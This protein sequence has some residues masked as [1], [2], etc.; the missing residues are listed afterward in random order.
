MREIISIIATIAAGY[1]G[2]HYA[3]SAGYVL[4]APPKPPAVTGR[5]LPSRRASAEV[6]KIGDTVE[7][8]VAYARQAK[9]PSGSVTLTAAII[10]VESAANPLAHN[11]DGEDSRGLMQVQLSTARGLH[12]N[13]AIPQ[14]DR[15][16]LGTLLFDPV[17]NVVI[18]QALLKELHGS[19]PVAWRR[20][21]PEWVIRAYNGGPDWTRKGAATTAATLRYHNA[22]AGAMRDV[23]RAL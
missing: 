9:V 5:L 12:D 13:G 17:A 8:A 15:A 2:W 19:V 22:V 18:G 16:K 3:Y 20:R 4:T 23:R 7:R 21:S 6:D 1:A 14:Y 10:V 11:T